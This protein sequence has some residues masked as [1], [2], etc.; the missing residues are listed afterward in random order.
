MRVMLTF[1]GL[2]TKKIEEAFL[3]FLSKAPEQVNALFIPTAA[4]DAEAIEGLPKCMN[5][6]LKVGIPK[7]INNFRCISSRQQEWCIKTA[8]FC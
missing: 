3:E 6:L 5:D 1:C 2:E 8:K 7:Q 4:I